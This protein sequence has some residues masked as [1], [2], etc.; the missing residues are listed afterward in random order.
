[1]NLITDENRLPSRCDPAC[2]RW[3]STETWAKEGDYRPSELR[4]FY[5]E[6]FIQL[7]EDFPDKDL[8]YMLIQAGF[9]LVNEVGEYLGQPDPIE[10]LEGKETQERPCDFPG[11]GLLPS[12]TQ[13]TECVL[14]DGVTLRGKRLVVQHNGLGP[15]CG[16]LNQD[17]EDDCEPNYMAAAKGRQGQI[18]GFQTN[19]ATGVADPQ[20]LEA[21]FQNGYCNSKAT[22]FEIYEQRLWEA[23][24]LSS[25]GVLD[26]NAGGSLGDC[27]FT[28]NANRTIRDWGEMLHE[29]RAARGAELSL[30]RPF[31]AMTHRFTFSRTTGGNDSQLYYYMHGSKCADGAKPRYGV[32]AVWPTVWTDLSLGRPS[33]GHAGVG[34]RRP[35]SAAQGDPGDRAL[36]RPDCRRS[37]ARSE[38]HFPPRGW[39][40]A[41]R[42]GPLVPGSSRPAR[43]Q[44]G[45]WAHY[46]VLGLEKCNAPAST[47]RTAAFAEPQL[48]VRGIS[49][50]TPTTASIPVVKGVRIYAAKVNDNGTVIGGAQPVRS[51]T[52]GGCNAWQPARF[53]PP[54]QI[55]VG[56][57]AFYVEAGG[58]T[59]L[60]LQCQKLEAH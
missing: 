11:R 25:T 14:K 36:E 35:G 51:L 32:I 39:R 58:F 2:P 54:D 41:V 17:G 28:P 6:Q 23:R 43:E 45:P 16:D 48:F 55:A 24:Q 50:C 8:S 42:A 19:N 9:P 18:I 31:P 44:S 38:R 21:A 5:R 60:A 30:D 52:L 13:Q 29:R 47:T 10:Q 1:M 22:F 20:Q 46:D 34:L 57:R 56:V 27:R 3:C 53:C 12:G 40:P 59:G 26:P 4:G 33:L 37:Q 15:L 7:A 49:V